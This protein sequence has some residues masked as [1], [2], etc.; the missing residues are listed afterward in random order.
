MRFLLD[1]DLP[2]K[3]AEIARSLGLAAVSIHELPRE[4]INDTEQ[5]RYATREGY[6]LVTRN[7]DDFARLS[8]EFYSRGE[9]YV[10]ILIVP[11]GYANNRPERIA[12]A[13][14]RWAD[15]RGTLPADTMLYLIEYLR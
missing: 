15:E 9:A 11:R 10:G 13:L 4:G 3:A 7:R 12:H 2:T 14:R 8:T 6:V 1:E 5:L